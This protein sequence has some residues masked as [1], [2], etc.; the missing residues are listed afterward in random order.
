[1]THSLQPEP[2][3]A[4][5]REL[6]DLARRITEET[7]SR[8][9]LEHLVAEQED[10]YHSILDNLQGVALECIGSDHTLLWVSK[11]IEEMVGQPR[12]ALAGHPC[13]RVI[14]GLEAPCPTCSVKEALASGEVQ[15]CER[16]GPN[17]R[18]WAVRSVPIKDAQGQ[19][20]K[21]LHFGYDI[22]ELQ[23]RAAALERSEQ[24]YR[25]LFEQAPI[26]IYS[27]D[28]AG[29]Y[30]SINPRHALMYGY[31]C[32]EDMRAATRESSKERFANPH[33]RDELLSLVRQLGR[34]AGYECLMTRKDGSRFWTSRTV[35]AIHDEHGELAG[36]MGYVEDIQERKQADDLRQDVD[37][38][39]RHDLKSPLTSIIA[40]P[41]LLL[42]TA[43]LEPQ[44][45]EMLQAIRAAGRRMLEMINSSL[46]LFQLE[47][48]EF[49]LDHEPV[50]LVELV[51]QVERDLQ[52]LFISKDVSLMQ[53][54]DP[55]PGAMIVSGDPTLLYSCLANLIKNALEASPEGQAIGVTGQRD[56]Q[57][58]TLRIH[59]QGQVPEGV[60]D[61]FFEKYVTAGKSG[62]TGLGTYSAALAVGA[63]GGA[64]AMDTSAR[65]GT[66]ITLRLPGHAV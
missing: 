19:V 31:D 23:A 53:A 26:G 49:K 46:V 40:L 18:S 63:H 56:G 10:L 8:R 17:G 65:A 38:I 7:E 59:N 25:A 54:Y 1:M 16:L 45:R 24:A 66:T 43:R 60:K 48:G 9:A 6:E 61:R 15:Q 64:I 13:F 44:E 39:M 4:C 30:L 62:G 12:K 58:V 3:E 36:Y 32:P 29:N 11:N 57:G 22:T 14:E 34:V 28:L 21:V 37:L 2:L 55:S 52:D 47:R 41:E 51:R 50:A 42:Q 5:R 20:E 35:R 27:V 33:Q